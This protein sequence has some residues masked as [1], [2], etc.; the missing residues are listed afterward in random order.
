MI[1]GGM[2]GNEP[3]GAAAAEV[4]RHWHI[5]KGKMLVIPS[6]NVPALNAK[7]RLIPDLATNLSNLNRNFP[8]ARQEE[9]PRGELATAIWELVVEYKP[10]WLLDLHEGFDFSRTNSRSVGSSLIVFPSPETDAV[11]KLMLDAVNATVPEARLRFMRR[12][13]P[14]NGSLARA[15]GEH[16][17]IPAMILETTSR[18]PFD[19]RSLQ[20]QVMVARLMQH[21]EM[22]ESPPASIRALEA[23]ATQAATTTASSHFM[24]GV[25]VALYQ[26]P[27][28]SGKGPLNLLQ[29]LNTGTNSSIVQVSPEEIRHGV[30]TNYDV[31]I[32]A[33]GSGSAQATALG[34]AGRDVVRQYI[35]I[36]AG[37]YLAT[38]G[39]SWGLKIINA[40]TVSS[41]WR[42]GV[43]E[44]KM[45]LTETGRGILG[46]RAGEF[47][48]HYANGPIVKPAN[49]PELPAYK[50]LAYFRTELAKNDSPPGV[51]VDS[52]AVIAAEYKRGRVVCISPHPEQTAGLDEIVP[53][54]VKWVSA[55]KYPSRNPGGNVE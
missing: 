53:R 36:C 1:V 44:V 11:A 39:F 49:K 13:M 17:K 32:F 30:L 47:A 26:G 50:C 33:G 7:K 5:V 12:G 10:D 9:P 40:Q 20:H 8:R 55:Q 34:D 54:V 35:G 2:H 21:L 42:R 15:A 31:V 28:T 27:G 37:A 19:K 25:K 24:P 52:P 46:E 4:I 14:V 29:R 41:K 23:A 6:A 45:E 16:L 22:L 48:V 43:G 38:S 51:M 3:A 18:Q